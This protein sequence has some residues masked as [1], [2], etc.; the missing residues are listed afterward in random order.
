MTARWCPY[1]GNEGHGDLVACLRCGEDH[2][3]ECLH[4]GEGVC[5]PCVK[6]SRKAAHEAAVAAYE[7][8]CE[9]LGEADRSNER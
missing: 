3:E 5:G 8:H 9:Q 7:D 2:C 6:A 1:C 4:R